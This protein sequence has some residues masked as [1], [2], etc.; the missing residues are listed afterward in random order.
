LKSVLDKAIPDA[1][2]KETALVQDGKVMFDPA[3]ALAG[4]E[5]KSPKLAQIRDE[6]LA[7]VAHGGPLHVHTKADVPG[8]YH[9]NL[10]VEGTYHPGGTMSGGHAH[11]SAGAHA[12]G[13]DEGQVFTRILT[14]MV[15]VDAAAGRP[16]V[17]AKRSKAAK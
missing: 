9:V 7:V 6:E 11:S 14:T 10:Y 2:R 5:R 15:V 8:A 13:E 4:L 17:A 1:M 12:A 3:I 16:Q